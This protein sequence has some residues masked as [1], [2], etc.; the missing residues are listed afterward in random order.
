MN[1]MILPK[2]KGGEMERK[3]S[4]N[5]NAQK[6]DSNFELLRI[7]AILMIILYHIQYHGPQPQLVSNNSYFAV[8]E[9][10]KRLLIFEIGSPLGMVSNHLFIL[11]S[12]Y[13]LTQKINIDTYK[14]SKN[15]LLQIGYA[16]ILLVIVSS[17]YIL[18]FN[19]NDINLKLMTISSFN[20]DWWFIGYY[21]LIVIIAKLFLNKF[22]Q[23]INQKEYLSFL[24]VIF[25]LTQLQW[26][27]DMLDKLMWGLRSTLVGVFLYSL[28]GYIYKY[29][30]LKKLKFSFI[31]FIIIATYAIRFISNY[32]LT[33]NNISTFISKNSTGNFIQQVQLSSRYEITAII[34]AICIFEIFRRIKLPNSKIVNY[35]GKSTLII[36]LIH[37]NPLFISLYSYC[38][39]MPVLEKGLFS[40]C[41]KWFSWAI[42]AFAVGVVAYSLYILIIKIASKCK[43]FVLNEEAE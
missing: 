35:L 20:S 1:K 13:F 41:I 11:I 10:Y 17:V 9:F 43:R 7:V 38:D 19:N 33:Q 34:L 42:L 32:N 16:T 8:P 40:Y 39:W 3:F 15:L 28:G 25:A 29:N 36:Y 4:M 2:L 30:P 27:G 37:E 31:V 18:T 6:R 24:I 21:L 14:V 12:G 23:Q 22:L 26:T 5:N